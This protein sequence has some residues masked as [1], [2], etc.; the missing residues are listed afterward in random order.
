S[1]PEQA[2]EVNTLEREVRLVGAPPPPPPGDTTP[3]LTPYEELVNNVR[4]HL[5]RAMVIFEPVEPIRP[6]DR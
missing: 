6:L 1:T 3:K 2:I 5:R 4:G